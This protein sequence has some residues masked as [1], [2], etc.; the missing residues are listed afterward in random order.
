MPTPTYT[1]TP[2][3]S[4]LSSFLFSSPSLSLFPSLYP[5]PY[6]PIC[7]SALPTG[8]RGLVNQGATCYMNVCLQVNVILCFLNIFH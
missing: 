4:S 1:H 2:T 8:V 3:S 5:S 7:E 6:T